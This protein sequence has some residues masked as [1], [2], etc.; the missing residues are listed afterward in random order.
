M[1]QAWNLESFVDALVV[2]LDR[3]RETLSVK[4]INKPLSY[5]VKDMALDLQI[6]PTYD[7]RQV[8]FMTAQPGELGSSK[9]SIQLSAITDRQVRES[10]KKPVA[11][12]DV[13]IEEIELD[14]DVMEH[15]RNIGVTSV[16][17][18]QRI[19]NRNVDLESVVKK[20]I[21]YSDLAKSIRGARRSKRP[22]RVQSASL[23]N[24]AQG[25]YRM[26]LEGQDLAIDQSFEP[27]VVINGELASLISRA[28]D[29]LT[30]SCPRGSIVDGDNELVLV[31]DPHSVVRVNVQL[32]EQEA[33]Q[34]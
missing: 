22:P 10:S 26:I 2:E 3:T 21:S 16:G 27:V 34:A 32:H 29:G 14:Q 4:A 5:T 28:R 23:T 15:L 13:R 11:K 25:G 31:L 12:D 6:F 19:E 7:G 24:D 9:V 8:Q 33:I 17:D 30:F 18:L 20:K 1:N